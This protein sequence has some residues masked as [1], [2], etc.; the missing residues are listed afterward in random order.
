MTLPACA[1]ELR[2]LQHDARIALTAI[3]RY[4]LPARR[5]AA[6]PPTAV[7]AVDRQDARKDGRTTKR[8]MDPAAQTMPAASIMTA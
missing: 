4:I 3:D 2:R 5:S 7:A 6:N 8:Y 1:A